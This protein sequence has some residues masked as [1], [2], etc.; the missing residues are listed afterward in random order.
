MPFALNALVSR[1][2]YA[3]HLTSSKNVPSICVAGR[4]ESAATLLVRGGRHDLLRQKRAKHTRVQVSSSDI[5]LRDQAPLHEANVAFED[6]WSFGDLIKALNQLVFF[7]PG[8][9]HGPNDYGRRHF[10]RY[11]HEGPAIV[12]VPTSDLLWS[13]PDVTPLLCGFNSGSL[14]F[15]GGVASPRGQQTFLPADQFPRTPS[16]VVELTF[17]VAIL[18]PTTTERGLSLDGPWSPLFSSVVP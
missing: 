9:A 3:Y 17:P 4:L 6:G 7:W 5:W 14:R 1:W 10:E 16:K 13:N 15:S 11:Q 12:R 2:P 18:L 8:S